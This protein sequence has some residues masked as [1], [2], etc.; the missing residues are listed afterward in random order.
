MIE[1]LV[2][3]A[4][5]F[6][7]IS[8]VILGFVLFPWFFLLLFLLVPLAAV[9]LRGNASLKGEQD[10]PVPPSIAASWA[11]LGLL[12]LSVLFIGLPAI[13]LGIWLHPSFFLILLLFCLLLAAPLWLSIADPAKTRESG[14]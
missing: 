10:E 11:I 14:R 4:A 5:L 8:A 3:A 6:I 1:Y 9:L 12:G 2:L 7:V 13:V